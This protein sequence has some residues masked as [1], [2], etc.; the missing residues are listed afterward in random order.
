[1]AAPKSL[2]AFI[3]TLAVALSVTLL[4]LWPAAASADEI[5]GTS[6]RH[7]FE[8]AGSPGDAAVVNLTP[9]LALGSGNG[10]LVSSDVTTPPVAAN[11]NYKIGT[12][13]PNV[14]IAPIGADGKVCYVNARQTSVH[15]VADHLG[16]IAATAYQTA[17][18]SGAPKRVTDTRA[19]GG[20]IGPNGRRCFTVAGSPGAAAV[21]NL[22]PVLA[23]GSGNG[24]LVSSDVTTPPVAANVNYKIGTVDPN[25]AIAPIGADGKVC[26]VNARQ[27][28]VHL[29]ADHLGTI[30]ATAYQTAT[31]SGAP[32]RVTDTRASGGIIGPNGRRCF[33]VAGSPG[34]AAVLNLT[35]VLALGSGNG[36]LVS[37]DVT[38][39]PVAANVNYKIGTVDP[40]VAIAP[41]GADGKVCYVNARQTSVH[42]VAD[43]LG[44]IAATAYQT[45]TASG[46]PKRVTDTRAPLP[47]FSGGTTDL[48]GK[49]VQ[50][51][52]VIKSVV[53]AATKPVEVYSVNLTAGQ[54]ILFDGATEPGTVIYE[55]WAPDTT[56]LW[57]SNDRLFRYSDSSWS[58]TP[59]ITG[60]YYFRISAN[61][62]HGAAYTLTMRNGLQ[63][64]VTGAPDDLPGIAT[65][66]PGTLRS[67]VDAATKPV[68]VYSVNLTA[69]QTIL[70]DGATEPGTVIYELWA[71]DT[72]I[73]WDSNDRLFRYSD[74]SWSFTPAITGTYYFRIS[75]NGYHGA[76][77]TL[78]M[79]NGLQVPVTGAPDDLPGIATTAPGTLRSVVDAATKPVE[80][81][82]VNLTAGQTILFDGATEPGTVIYELWAPDTTILWDSNDRLFRYSD[83]SWSFTP[84]ITG[85]YYFRI[86]ANGY[87]GAAYTLTMRN[88]LQ[89]PV[90]GAPDDLPGIATTAPGTLR[91]VVDAATKPVEVYSVNLTAGQTILF[92]GAT[93]PGTVIYELW[94]PDTTILWDSNDRLFR[95][96]DS[97]WSF[98]P[99]ITGTYYFRISANGYHG[100]AYTLTTRLL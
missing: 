84:A 52:G 3:V 94:A 38:T 18:A 85:T 40:N 87:H 76:A 4:A 1:M 77:Y 53:D 58:F 91:S 97:S 34:A 98:T 24:L 78:T 59:A 50:V 35:P 92:D 49:R 73:L 5:I 36:L 90:T 57:D 70:F 95:Y 67:V 10:L 66:A 62:Y 46:A 13:D 2:L 71:P 68:E 32:K 37:S 15:L 23:L 60:T 29:V 43:H 21:L 100:A 14:A 20:I 65:T 80:V 7:C 64:P 33:T 22:T 28:S 69:G 51:P 48:P 47:Q 31:A 75:A 79:R 81:Y 55:L 61:G 72:T 16:T 54:T 99:A 82:S 89:V 56:I 93:E 41:I 19:S 42:L 11:V 25:V 83:S 74:S 63:V 96:S 27:T 39:P 6:G 86:S 45:A 88:G 12:V 44:T 9:V 17:T 26:Y 8:V 30:A